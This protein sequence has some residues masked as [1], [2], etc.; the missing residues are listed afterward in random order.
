MEN[1]R[2][3]GNHQ[4][5]WSDREQVLR[6][7]EPGEERRDRARYRDPADYSAIGGPED[8][9][10]YG[11]TRSDTGEYPFGADEGAADRDM[12]ARDAARGGYRKLHRP[13]YGRFS[14]PDQH[15]P[16][17]GPRGYRRSD[18]RLREIVCEM[19]ADDPHIDATNIEVAVL[20]AEVTLAGYVHTRSEKRWADRLLDR[21]DDL[22][23]VHN[24][25]R[26]QSPEGTK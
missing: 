16:K 13:D 11:R 7:R 18:E 26:V 2:V 25:L 9:R 14:E 12:Y 15:Q 20:N 6:R 3:E 22:A 17:R 8:Q 1:R 24:Q 4:E 10:S 21:I 19:L 23:D 5:F